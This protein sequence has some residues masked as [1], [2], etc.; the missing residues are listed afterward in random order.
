MGKLQRPPFKFLE[1][2]NKPNMYEKQQSHIS[3][4]FKGGICKKSIEVKK[5]EREFCN[6]TITKGI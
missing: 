4:F 3:K 5:F 2:T 1:T 6:K